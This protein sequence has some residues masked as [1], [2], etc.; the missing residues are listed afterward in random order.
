MNKS[1]L[2]EAIAERAVVSKKQAENMLNSFC[3]AVADELECGG[4]VAITGFGTFS[5]AARAERQGRNPKTG[6]TLTI[7]ANKAVKFKAGKQL[8]E[9]VN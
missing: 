1:E 8:K 6:E 5:V 4:E 7:A 3:Y 9:A 2:I